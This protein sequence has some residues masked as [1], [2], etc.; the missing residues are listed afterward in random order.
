MMR[1]APRN[2]WLLVLGFLAFSTSG[3]PGGRLIGAASAGEFF[4]KDGDRVVMIGD[5]ITEQHLYSNYVEMWTV[6]RFPDWNISFWN[7]GIGGDRSV[8]GESRF[9]R[10]VLSRKPTAM[11]V[12]FGMNDAG[13]RVFDEGLFGAYMGGLRGMARKAKEANLR[14][15]WITPQPIEPNYNAQG[16]KFY[17]ETLEKFSAGVQTIAQENGATFVDQFHPWK[18]TMDK[19]TAADPA[20][21]IGGGDAVHPG[22]PGQALMAWAILKGLNFPPRVS[23]VEIEIVN[24]K[25]NPQVDRCGVTN[26]KLEANGLSFDRADQAFPFF[27]KDA[28]GILRWTPVLEDLNEYRLRVIGLADGKYDLSLDGVSIG[29]YA[30]TDLAQG[31]NLAS[32]VLAKGPIADHVE[33]IWSAVQAKNRFHHDRIFRGAVLAPVAIPDFLGIEVSNEEIEAKRRVA[34]EERLGKYG[35][36]EHAVREA[37][38]PQVHHVKLTKSA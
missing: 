25:I 38:K 17:N 29:S 5:S 33:R 37:S 9:E 30:S 20:N 36:F 26:L 23:S 1:F 12:D 27:P 14:V 11:T 15:A 32:A 13:Y 31:V 19:A 28:E 3:A 34:V 22:A 18:E 8:G 7:V 16:M 4:F 10:D 35:E 24:D 6:S 21:Q 2:N